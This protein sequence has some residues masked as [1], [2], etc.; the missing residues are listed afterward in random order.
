MKKES[1]KTLIGLNVVFICLSAI[2]LY[3]D[4]MAHLEKAKSCK[5]ERIKND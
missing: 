4:T 5:L 3:F 2:F 1:L